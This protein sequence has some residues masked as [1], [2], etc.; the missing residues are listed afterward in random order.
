[1]A[2]PDLTTI[3]RRSAPLPAYTPRSRKGCAITR[4]STVLTWQTML[5]F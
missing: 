1:V 3:L 5:V 2:T 4:A